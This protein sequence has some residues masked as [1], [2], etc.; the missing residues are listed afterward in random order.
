[1]RGFIF[2][3]RLRSSKKTPDLR[4]RAPVLHRR[5]ALI[6]GSLV[7][8]QSAAKNRPLRANAAEALL[9]GGGQG[10]GGEV[11]GN[12]PLK[13]ASRSRTDRRWPRC[14]DLASGRSMVNP[15]NG[16]RKQQADIAALLRKARFAVRSVNANI[17]TRSA[18]AGLL[19]CH[20]KSRFSATKCR[21]NSCSARRR[22]WSASKRPSPRLR[23][24]RCV[25]VALH[26]G[27]YRFRM[28]A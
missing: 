2:F 5:Y 6:A 18:Y 9:T 26:I 11:P 22:S 28:S 19:L 14:A 17:S 12:P 3:N 20:G 1:M 25:R 7:G 4:D 21:L 10:N 8:L 15:P 16:F 23:R 24:C 27:P 13:S